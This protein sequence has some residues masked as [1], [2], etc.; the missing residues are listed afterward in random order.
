MPDS[1]NKDDAR[2]TARPEIISPLSIQKAPQGHNG[3]PAQNHGRLTVISF[4]LFLIAVVAAGGWLFSYLKSDRTIANPTAA[5]AVAERDRGVDS[6]PSSRAEP[7]VARSPEK[8]TQTGQKNKAEGQRSAYVQVKSTLETMGVSSWGE[9]LYEEMKVLGQDAE[10]LFSQHEFDASIDQF[11]SAIEKANLLVNGAQTALNKLIEKGEEAIARGDAQKAQ[12]AFQKALLIDPSNTAARSGIERAQDTAT[13]MRLIETGILHERDGNYAQAMTDYNQALVLDPKAEKALT[14]RKRVASITEEAQ[15]QRLM[16]EGQSALAQRNLEKARSTLLKA[17]ALRPQDPGV[18]DALAQT[19]QAIY[20][21]RIENL[22]RSAI[23]AEKAE[24][25]PEALEFYQKVLQLDRNIRL[26]VQGEARSRD[27]IRIN[28]R[29]SYFL[30]KP[31]ALQSDRQLQNALSLVDETENLTAKGPG[32][33]A[34][35]NE[36]KTLIET[37]ETPVRFII[38]SDNQTEVAIY[39]VGKFGRFTERELALRPGTYTVVGSREGYQDVRKKFK[40]KPGQQPQRITV[41][42]TVKV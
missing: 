38:E 11:T 10:T 3:R 20:M 15:F 1:S 40:V 37:A 7:K 33:N 27:Y 2:K 21:R 9:I 12:E 39:K 14:G 25:W 34:R 29:I 23:Q 4:S 19:D 41:V 18:I 35:I 22:H 28:K 5:P 36:L 16:S 6:P 32:L 24:R 17:K 30:E 8:G 31:S 42:C 13:V 26:A